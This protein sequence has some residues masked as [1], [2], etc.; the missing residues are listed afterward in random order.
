M[1]SG[2][3][4][5]AVATTVLDPSETRLE[6]DPTRR[7]RYTLTTCLAVAASVLFTLSNV[8]LPHLTGSTANV[9]A[10]IP[11]VVNRLLAAKLVYAVG[12]LLLIPFVVALWRV[13]ARR[14]AA[15]RLVGGCLLIVGGLCNAL[16]E[17]TEAYLAW[18]MHHVG[19]GATSQVRLFDLLDNSTAALPISF[20]AIPVLSLGILL[21]MVG[22]LRARVVPGWLPGVTI[23]G[24]IAS[25]V[26][27]V[28]L[29]ALVGLV[30]ALPAAAVVI[31]TAGPATTRA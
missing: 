14:G 5:T 10:H 13:D 23:V 1:T 17:V 7:T 2:A 29:P 30:W 15:L 3:L 28:G 4:M 25:S 9:V 24:G 31:L 12:S 11:A 22:V 20:I 16:G 19:I 26:A 18:G 27:G 6:A 21:L 8:F